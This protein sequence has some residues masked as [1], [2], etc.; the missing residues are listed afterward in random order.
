MTDQDFP[1]GPDPAPEPILLT[2]ADAA[3]QLGVHYMTAYRYVRTGRLS[4][5]KERG[6]WWVAPE[7]LALIAVGSRIPA[8]DEPTANPGAKRLSVMLRRR[9]IAGDDAGAWSV[10]VE[11]MA[12]GM[13]PD[14]IHTEM[15]V[16]ALDAVG[17]LWADGQLTIVDEHQATAVMQRVLG[18]MTPLFRHPGRRR[19]TA[20]LGMVAGDF[21][22]LP[23]AILGDLLANL[24]FN[25]I[26]L[27]GNSPAESFIEAA[28]LADG[29][30]I[31][32][33]C[34]LADESEECMRVAFAE[35]HAALPD[36]PIILGGPVGAVVG[37]TVDCAGFSRTA[38]EALQ[39]F[40]SCVPVKA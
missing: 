22:A 35:V 37:P 27:G 31:I 7:E 34:A 8:D 33:M 30:A 3:E 13:T 39:V 20:V 1:T 29:P 25:V 16:P 4:A 23:T 24:R 38:D 9:A 40:E 14:R 17:E 11:A 15:I 6:Q 21:H 18:R 5:T 28:G 19:A 36:V 26:D 32:G 10:V 12:S 2:L